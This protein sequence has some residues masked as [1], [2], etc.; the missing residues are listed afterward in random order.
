MVQTEARPTTAPGA[1][2]GIRVLDFTWVRAGPWC[3]RWLGALGAEV[4]KVEWPRNPNTR[5]E[6]IGGRR[7]PHLPANLNT[8]GHFS[9]TNANK[10]SVTINSRTA[11]GIDLIK[12]LVTLSDIVIENFSHDVLERWGLGYEDMK[13]TPA[14]YHLSLHVRVWSHGTGPRLQ[15]HGAYRPGAVGY[16]LLIRPSGPSARGVGLV[17]HG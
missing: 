14:R 15:D 9:D 8:D 17:I 2:T 16:D 3:N 4:V 11:R 5:G 1:L 6:G 12:R 7:P 13:K 10:L